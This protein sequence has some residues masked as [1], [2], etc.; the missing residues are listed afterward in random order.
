M[1]LLLVRHGETVW[2]AERRLQGQRDVPLSTLGE[3]QA[4]SL[5]PVVEE[6]RPTSAVASPLA[7]AARTL[8]LLGH[9]E[10]STDA[11]W[12]EANLGEWTGRTATEL[13]SMGE[14]YADWRAGRYTPPGGES[15]ES[16]TDRV[17][18]AA[19]ELTRGEGVALVVTHGGPIRA[20]IRH[21]IG[22]APELMVPVDPASLT[23]VDFAEGPRLRAYSVQVAAA[24]FSPPD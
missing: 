2:N 7:R 19:D 5:R 23:I 20:I 22:L 17:V 13:L 12:M 3:H 10:A 15:F 14:P 6:H 8:A 24:R 11:R 16:L 18:R 9:P 4:V 1:R 21:Y